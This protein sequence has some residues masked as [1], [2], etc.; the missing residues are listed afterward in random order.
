M[1]GYNHKDPY[2]EIEPD[3]RDGGI[4][5]MEAIFAGVRRRLLTGKVDLREAKNPT[6]SLRVLRYPKTQNLNTLQLEVATNTNEWDSIACKTVDEWCDGEDYWQRIE[7]DLSRY[8]GK[9]VYIGFV[10][11]SETHTWTLFDAMEI[12]ERKQKNLGHVSL[13]KPETVNCGQSF[14]IVVRIRNHGQNKAEGYTL[15]LFRDGESVQTLDGTPLEPGQKADFSFMERHDIDAKDSYRYYVMINHTGDQDIFDNRSANFDITVKDTD[16]PAPQN[17]TGNH[18]HETNR[19]ELNWEAP[20]IPEKPQRITDDFEKYESWSNQATGVGDY[21]FLDYDD[22]RIVDINSNG[23]PIVFPGIEPGSKQSWFVFDN[24]FAP[25]DQFSQAQAHSGKKYMAC[26][27]A[28]GTFSDD[29]LISPELSGEEQTISFWARTFQGNYPENF[30][31]HWSYDGYTFRDMAHEETSYPL[32]GIVPTEWTKY[33][34]KLP[35]GA[36]Y[37]AIR[38]YTN[39]GM[40]LFL[41]DLSYIPAGH[42]RLKLEGYNVYCDGTQLNGTTPVTA[43]SYT[44]VPEDGNHTYSVAAQYNLGQSPLSQ[45]SVGFTGIDGISDGLSVAGAKGYV[46]VS[47]AVGLHVEILSADGLKVYSAIPSADRLAIP[48]SAGVYAVKVADK[49]FKVM[50]R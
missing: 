24:T 22:T 2:M 47:G 17:L 7:V 27:Q 38:R 4:A 3:D 19:V 26:L 37:F 18:N 1:W 41:D 10:A 39:H 28:Y 29:W 23:V 43:T 9:I 40:F 30:M 25:F 42:E 35:A 49:S 32:V 6:L 45:V 21:H 46:Y 44:H 50:V 12:S 33:E 16:F 34:F 20:V 13:E 31:I 15:E 5:L 36:R 14:P 11:T 8:V 48:V